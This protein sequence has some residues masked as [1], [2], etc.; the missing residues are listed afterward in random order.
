MKS[1]SIKKER[2]KNTLEEAD[3]VY[4][5]FSNFLNTNI[6]ESLGNCTEEKG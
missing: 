5:F 4:K 2:Q 6:W 3:K 1:V